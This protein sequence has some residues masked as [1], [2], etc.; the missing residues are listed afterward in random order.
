V[1]DDPL[2]LSGTAAML[3]ELGHN[4]T[5]AVSSGA[6]ALI[7]LN[8]E[9]QVDLLLTDNLM[10]GMTG[11][12]LAREARRLCPQLPILVASGFTENDGIESQDWPRLRKP[13]GLSDLAR[14]LAEIR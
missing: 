8:G 7:L 3:E 2:V 10:P 11:L 1:D 13:Y 12:Q 6:E 4:V 5:Q 14:A 9:Q